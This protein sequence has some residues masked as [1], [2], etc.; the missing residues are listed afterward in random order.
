MVWVIWKRFSNCATFGK[1]CSC[2][3]GNIWFYG[4]WNNFLTPLIIL[5]DSEMFTL[6][7]GL[8]TFKG[9]YISY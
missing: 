3:T 9:Q 5:S 2:S 1:T 6:P 4:A 7:L 8:N